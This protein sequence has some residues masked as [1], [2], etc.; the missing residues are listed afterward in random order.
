MKASGNKIIFDICDYHYDNPPLWD[1]YQRMMALADVVTF[2]SH[3]LQTEI[4]KVI[5]LNKPHMVISDPPITK[6]KRPK[7]TKPMEYP[8]I[9]W[10]GQAPSL[11]NLQDHIK[12]LPKGNLVVL[13][14]R[15]PNWLDAYRGHVKPVN[16]SE[17]ALEQCLEECDVVIIPQANHAKAKGKSANRLVEAVNSQRMVVAS[18]VP[19]YLPFADKLFIGEDISAL[20]NQYLA[21]PYDTCLARLRDAKRVM[22]THYSADVVRSQWIEAINL[23]S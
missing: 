15:F 19:S 18:P 10:F 20:V 12:T 21:T 16:W 7:A 5:V 13:C 8:N 4:L 23:A 3:G 22:D 1:H 2:S 9:L 17:D 11:T 14:D 6:A